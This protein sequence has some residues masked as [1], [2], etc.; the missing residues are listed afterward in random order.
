MT[1]NEQIEAIKNADLDTQV[2]RNVL[3]TLR[4]IRSIY[5]AKN[6]Y[7]VIVEMSDSQYREYMGE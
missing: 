6:N 7:S 4:M 5:S 1:I 3:K 2:K